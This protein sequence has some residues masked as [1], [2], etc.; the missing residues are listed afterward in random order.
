M[1]AEKRKRLEAAGW[2]LGTVDEILV[3]SPEENALVELK[4][5]LSSTLRRRREEALLSQSALAERIHS[6][7]PRVAKLEAGGEG[8]TLDLLIRAL[9]ATGASRRDIGQVIASGSPDPLADSTEE[10]EEL[11]NRSDVDE[12]ERVLAG[13]R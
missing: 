10:E 8:A 3:L 6:S 9:L 13:S 1:N 4:L 12:S 5:L 2:K 11:L 7:Q